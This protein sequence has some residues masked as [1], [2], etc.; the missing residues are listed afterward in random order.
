MAPRVPSISRTTTGQAAPG[1]VATVSW[2][3]LRFLGRN[4]PPAD[5]RS[6]LE[7]VSPRIVP[8][9]KA[10]LEAHGDVVGKKHPRSP[11]GTG[12]GTR[13][14]GSGTT[15]ARRSRRTTLR[16]ASLECTLLPSVL[17]RLPMDSDGLSPR[18][19][20]SGDTQLTL[21]DTRDTGGRRLSKLHPELIRIRPR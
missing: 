18:I 20:I 19:G 14:V 9:A 15:R 3:S 16:P 2:S 12:Q 7:T 13:P 8:R 6:A 4:V 17:L 5:L 1:E 21:P 10:D 11:Q